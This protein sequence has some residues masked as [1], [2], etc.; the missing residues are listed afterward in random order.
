[1]ATPEFNK[2]AVA[3]FVKLTLVDILCIEEGDVTNDANLCADLGAD[4]LD[5]VDITLAIEEE[6]GHAMVG[7]DTGDLNTVGD[8][9]ANI[10]RRLEL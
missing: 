6:F 1:M 5:S 9:I 8:Y 3:E 10:E 7:E 2:A 4:S